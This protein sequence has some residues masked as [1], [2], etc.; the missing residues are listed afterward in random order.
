MSHQFES[1]FVVG[2]QA[3]HGLATV[4]ENAPT[5]QEAIV[6]AGLNWN[7]ELVENFFEIN[8]EK[9]STGNFSCVR[10]TDGQYLGTVEGRY[11]VLQNV[12]AFDFV[13]P[14]VESGKVTLETAGS[15]CK[16]KIVWILCKIGQDEIKPGDQVNSYL[17]FSHGHGGIMRIVCQNTS[18][19]VVCMNTLSA[20]LDS[21]LVGSNAKFKGKKNVGFSLKHTAGA[22]D[23]LE[24]AQKALMDAMYVRE[25]ELAIYRRMTETPIRD[26]QF[27]N[28]LKSLFC[29]TREE[30]EIEDVVS[31]MFE[32]AVSQPSLPKEDARERLPRA[33]GQVNE[34]YRNAPGADPG[35]IWGAY[36]A[37]TYYLD[38]SR[39]RTDGNRLY[40]SWFGSSRNIRQEAFDNAVA[41]LQ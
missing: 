7:V 17:L 6:Q 13:N 27:Q 36:N 8:G 18:I 28:Y 29:K 9:K 5:C 15:L 38:H 22:K 24:R 11:E 34:A 20:S 25:A 4:L 39:G 3:W 33:I 37:V 30:M 23:K 32:G 35:T 14:L 12:E 10:D 1:G 19:R 31:S 40:N 26:G 16:G 41:L 2:K 21:E